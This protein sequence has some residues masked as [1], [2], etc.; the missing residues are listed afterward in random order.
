MPYAL[1]FVLLNMEKGY[2]WD[3]FFALVRESHTWSG[4]PNVLANWQSLHGCTARQAE[5]GPKFFFDNSWFMLAIDTVGHH[6][7]W[8]HRYGHSNGIGVPEPK[9]TS[10]L[11][12]YFNPIFLCENQIKNNLQHIFCVAYSTQEI[13]WY[14]N[15]LTHNQDHPK[16]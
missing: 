15:S 5:V 6:T 7:V 4:P 14:S 11:T 12:S 9:H 8:L 10:P 13:F 2:K 16:K 3:P 1:L